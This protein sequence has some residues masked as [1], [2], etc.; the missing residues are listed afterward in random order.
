VEKKKQNQA[1]A[2]A[3]FEFLQ[4][5]QGFASNLLGNLIPGG[6]TGGLVGGGSPVQ[7][8]LQPVASAADGRSQTGPTAG[9]GNATN[10]ILTQILQQLKQINGSQAAPEANRQRAGQNAIFDYQAGF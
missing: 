1:L 10:H 5:Q 7:S 4:A 6:A 8:A 9:Q 3:T 2:T